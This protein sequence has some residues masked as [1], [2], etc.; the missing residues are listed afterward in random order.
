MCYQ[1]CTHDF[2]EGRGQYYQGKHEKKITPP[3]ESIGDQIKYKKK[4]FGL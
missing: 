1:V 3:L 4:L 2:G